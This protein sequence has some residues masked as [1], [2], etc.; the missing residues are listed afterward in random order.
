M[1]HLL[2]SRLFGQRF[3]TDPLQAG[4]PSEP[5]N[6]ERLVIKYFFQDRASRAML[7]RRAQTGGTMQQAMCRSVA[8]YFKGRQFLWTLPQSGADGGVR[9]NF[10]KAEDGAFR[11]RL[12]LPGRCFGLNCPHSR[13]LSD[14]PIAVAV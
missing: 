14:Q 6:G 4:L 12:R 3:A 7:A 5:T 13:A 8:E 1:T 9:D 11:P 10:W 2:W